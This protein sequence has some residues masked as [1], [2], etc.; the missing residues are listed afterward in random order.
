MKNFTGKTFSQFHYQFNQGCAALHEKCR[1]NSLLSTKFN[2]FIHTHDE[3]L[4][5]VVRPEYAMCYLDRPHTS[6]E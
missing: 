1:I 6:L 5:H 4:K 2:S 3:K